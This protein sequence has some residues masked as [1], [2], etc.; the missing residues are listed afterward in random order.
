VKG[1]STHPDPL[2]SIVEIERMARLPTL[3]AIL[4]FV[5]GICPSLALI[6]V[7]TAS[8]L[9]SAVQ[10][11]DVAV[12]VAVVTV[13]IIALADRFKASLG[14]LIWYAVLVCSC[15]VLRERGVFVDLTPGFAIVTRLLS[16]L[17]ALSAALAFV[18][19]AMMQRKELRD[20]LAQKL[21]EVDKQRLVAQDAAELRLRFLADFSHELRTPL[22]GVVG[23]TELLATKSLSPQVQRLV[24]IQRQSADHLLALVN[25]VL[26]HSV[27]EAGRLVLAP[28]PFSIRAVAAEVTEM[29]AANAQAKG[30]ELTSSAQAR[31]PPALMGDAVRIRQILANLVVNA[32]RH[33][34]SGSV[35]ILIDWLPAEKK[36]PEQLQLRVK[37]TGSGMSQRTQRSLLE[38]YAP[39]VTGTSRA[40]HGSGLGLSICR[41]LAQLMHGSIDIQSELGLGTTI[42]VVLPLPAASDASLPGLQTRWDGPP[43]IVRLASR[44]ESLL[45]QLRSQLDDLGLAHSRMDLGPREQSHP[46]VTYQAEAENEIFVVDARLLDDEAGYGS[47]AATLAEI[48]A[49]RVVFVLDTVRDFDLHSWPLAQRVYRPVAKGALLAALRKVSEASTLPASTVLLVDDNPINQLVA[50][51]MLEQLGAAVTT[52]TSGAQAM[53]LLEQMQFDLVLM[54]LIVPGKNGIECTQALRR[55]EAERNLPAQRVFALTSSVDSDLQALCTAAGMQGFVAK[56]VTLQALATVLQRERAQADVEPA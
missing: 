33:T 42:T 10:L 45:R 7:L 20:L 8:S 2:A 41:H 43:A 40:M 29:Y 38:G 34:G 32:L 5:F 13:I 27:I 35:E 52:A 21:Q 53:Q 26:D 14:L 51:S 47:V 28:L 36:T 15:E 3:R 24:S 37:D 9:N 31:V 48:P 4:L 22:N 49:S 1:P 11:I 16:W 25:Q 54:D 44:S 18:R 17:W 30:L 12:T 23:A 56:P 39:S 19:F 55:L 6:A 46:G 50:R